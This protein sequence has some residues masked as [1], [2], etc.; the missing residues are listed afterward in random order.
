MPKTDNQV[1]FIKRCDMLNMEVFK[2]TYT[3]HAFSRHW[4]ESFG[5]GLIE[6][7][8]E[9]FDY[10]AEK[11]YAPK[12]SIILMNPG[13]IHTGQAVNQD[14]GW[15][16]EIMYP[17]PEL[18][19]EIVE[20][21]T[22][23]NSSPPH[24]SKPVVTDPYSEQMLK[25]LFDLLFDESSSAL[26]CQSYFLLAMATLIRNHADL[27]YEEKQ[28][29]DDK[30]ISNRIRE[31]IDCNYSQ[32][33]TLSE[34]ASISERSPFHTLR[35]FQKRWNVPPHTYQIIVRI[36]KAKNML[37]EGYP[38]SSIACETGFA[39]QSHFTRHFKRIVGITPRE[40]QLRFTNG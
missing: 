38:I 40:Y 6:N 19:Q 16:Y 17:V 11:Y 35:I 21:L 30:M 15:H 4:H 24:F 36:Q 25:R 12:H 18:L 9:V 32:N 34:L 31:Y 39:D 7:G 20:Q 23:K 37:R 10:Q 13:A 5:I 27:S 1:K 28:P 3:T 33:I 14:E 8:V 26:E 22:D 29:D 2:S